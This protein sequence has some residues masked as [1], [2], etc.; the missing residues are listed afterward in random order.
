[1]TSVFVAVDL[2]AESGRVALI[3]LQRGAIRFQE[4]H[5]FP[6]A[7]VVLPSGLHWDITGIWR[8][9]CQG[10]SA[11][12]R[13]AAENNATI[14]SIGVDAWG[15]D[16]TLV[17]ASG[18]L[19]GLPHAYRDPR[20]VDA[21][22]RATSIVSPEQI[23][24]ATGIQNMPI[25]SL[26]SLYAQKLHGPELL[27]AADQLLFI[28]DLMNFWL[29]GKRNVEA[30]VAS[31]SQVLD[32]RSGQWCRDLLD[33]LEL[34]GHL[35]RETSLPGTALGPIS[36]AL[37]T[38]TGLDPAVQVIATASHDT[39]SAVA[40]VP[41]DP[42]SRWC[43]LSS[44]TWSLL[45]AELGEPCIGQSVQSAMFTN[46]VGVAGT[47]RFLKNIA[48]LWLVQECR[49]EFA[50]RGQ[51]YDYTELADM[52]TL[53]EPFRT[54]VDPD[55]ESFQT[56]G[57][58]LAKIDEFARQTD[59]P[60][61]ETPGDYLRCCLE[62]LALKYRET[63][64]KL[65]QTLGQEFEVIHI[66]GGGGRN[67]LLNQLT[68]SATSRPVLAGPFE[69]TALGNALVQAMALDEIANLEE[70]RL[71]VRKSLPPRKYTPED[72]D[73]WRPAIERFSSLACRV[74]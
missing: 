39:A 29:C 47:I 46:E 54:F 14:L 72:P 7:P 22:D 4:I 58:M 59:Q 8:E 49:R 28:P 2:G 62:G 27:Q 70:I 74:A 18:E 35:F 64:I 15:V 24:Q 31:T 55:F 17:G 40:A 20:N 38:A 42:Q 23:Y 66:V 71:L 3:E 25:N 19:V 52:A 50:S 36:P 56:P 34:P 44:G 26:F 9:I 33:R 60:V 69:A 48:G 43:F 68:A 65:E 61:P 16:W 32:V 10:L 63:L 41:A 11:A 21:F 6:N 1:M 37:A 45:G 73:I 53:A 12:A 51:E 5:R 57:N 67:E 30:T 13:W